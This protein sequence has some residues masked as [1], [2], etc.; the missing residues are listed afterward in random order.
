MRL[1]VYCVRRVAQDMCTHSREL[2][3]VVPLIVLSESSCQYDAIQA[4]DKNMALTPSSS[5]P[6]SARSIRQKLSPI[7]FP[8]Y[9]TS[10]NASELFSS[11]FEVRSR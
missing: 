4:G 3:G 11:K 1:L 10:H 7:W 5:K 2:E 8:A 6:C 9:V